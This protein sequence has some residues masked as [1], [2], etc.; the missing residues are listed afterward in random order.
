MFANEGLNSPRSLPNSPR[1]QS[2]HRSGSHGRSLPNSPHSLNKTP[3]MRSSSSAYLA[4]PKGSPVGSTVSAV[5]APSTE[6]FRSVKRRISLDRPDEMIVVADHPIAARM[7][8]ELQSQRIGEVPMGTRVHVVEL[9]DMDNGAQRARVQ[10]TDRDGMMLTGWVTATLKNGSPQLAAAPLAAEYSR[11]LLPPS[12]AELA[13]NSSKE[14]PVHEFASA[15]AKYVVERVESQKRLSMDENREAQWLALKQDAAELLRADRDSDVETVEKMLVRKASA[16]QESEKHLLRSVAGA[17]ERA[18]TKGWLASAPAQD[19]PGFSAVE[20][21]KAEIKQLESKTAIDVPV[22]LPAATP[23]DSISP[24]EKTF[25]RKGAS[26]ARLKARSSKE[27][28]T[29]ITAT[30][31]T[32]TSP[33]PSV[34]QSPKPSLPSTKG[35]KELVTG[36][37]PP[38][39]QSPTTKSSAKT[40][41]SP[42]PSALL[43]SPQSLSPKGTP[44]T[45]PLQLKSAS[46]TT[47]LSPPVSFPG[48]LSADAESI[49]NGSK[50][51]PPFAAMESLAAASTPA[52]SEPSAKA[53][54]SA[55]SA[56]SPASNDKRK[57]GLLL[58]EPV[59]PRVAH[60]M[61]TK[62]ASKTDVDIDPIDAIAADARALAMAALLRSSTLNTN[63]EDAVAKTS[64]A[65]LPSMAVS[66]LPSRS[67]CI[68]HAHDTP[69]SANTSMVPP[70]AKGQA[71]PLK[72]QPS[73]LSSLSAP[74]I[75]D[76]ATVRTQPTEPT[77]VEEPVWEMSLM[78][79]RE[80]Y[81]PPS[82]QPLEPLLP[83]DRPESKSSPLKTLHSQPSVVIDTA[84]DPSTE[85]ALAP[86]ALSADRGGVD[87][88]SSVPSPQASVPDTP[89]EFSPRVEGV[90]TTPNSEP[91]RLKKPS[92]AFWQIEAERKSKR[93]SESPMLAPAV[94]PP[95][96]SSNFVDPP[97]NQPV[98]ES[99]TALATADVGRSIIPAQTV[100]SAEEED[101]AALASHAIKVD[102]ENRALRALC[103]SL[104]ASQQSLTSKLAELEKR[105]ITSTDSTSSSEENALLKAQITS[106]EER[107]KAMESKATEVIE[108]P[109]RAQLPSLAERLTAT[110]LKEKKVAAP[111][112]AAPKSNEV[113]AP[114][115]AAPKSR[116]WSRVRADVTQK[117]ARKVAKACI[118]S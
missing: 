81:P 72:H 14:L 57:P 94:E 56:S 85:A 88:P 113:A 90:V 111:A 2:L 95:A 60:G 48:V 107:L 97:T 93:L 26:M 41:S 24:T 69:S 36:N 109:P 51:A 116:R 70:P 20:A 67:R 86:A 50:T 47:T 61:P 1:R 10:W 54:T 103:E 118:I 52:L 99:I 21:M 59:K 65:P 11:P 115:A 84:V 92:R 106:L 89:L 37:T 53:A 64:P 104:T 23:A 22:D 9:W 32:S 19:K 114:A 58:S 30:S 100:H 38:S 16:R 91:R 15:A 33:L 102:A 63:L 44:T 27:L 75:S 117:K 76:T 6:Q 101:R 73:G 3:S 77:L 17:V 29:G 96:K 49:E 66:S 12:L 108:L 42:L 40:H 7:R 28:F 105:V 82:L 8:L 43:K 71:E 112:A 62:P 13:P 79:I 83:A 78:Q 68:S 80:D 74:A 18:T 35:A 34:D 110:G 87:T 98:E 31:S 25:L 4:S 5:G 39:P 46:W 45:P 55:D